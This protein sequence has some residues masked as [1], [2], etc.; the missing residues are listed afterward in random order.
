MGSDFA[1][2]NVEF[3]TNTRYASAP[4]RS[5]RCRPSISTKSQHVTGG[6]RIFAVAFMLRTTLLT[7]R[8]ACSGSADL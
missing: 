6:S 5:L 4:A 7:H 8:V 2:T 1:K 3:A